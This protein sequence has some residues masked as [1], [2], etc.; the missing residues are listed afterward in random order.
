M[1]R[2]S[3]VVIPPQHNPP[4]QAIGAAL[5]QT[6]TVPRNA[7]VVADTCRAHIR[8]RCARPGNDGLFRSANAH[9]DV[10][11]VRYLRGCCHLFRRFDLRRN[12]DDERSFPG[13]HSRSIR[14]AVRCRRTRMGRWLDRI[15]PLKIVAS[16]PALHGCG[17]VFIQQSSS[18]RLDPTSPSCWIRPLTSFTQ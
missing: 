18:R 2:R 17:R 8:E 5:L 12:S 16:M 6:Q 14:C 3:H 13:C 15:Q 11:D 4:C 10:Q 9:G 7:C 1:F